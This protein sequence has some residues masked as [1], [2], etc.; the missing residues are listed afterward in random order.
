MG[1]VA[2][3]PV[4]P[5]LAFV[6]LV[7]MSRAMRNKARWVSVAAILGSLGLSIAAF[8]HVWPGGHAGEP[9]YHA[10]MTLATLGGVPLQVGL[11]LDAVSAAM[12][13]VI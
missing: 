5:A 13:I 6:V 11:M 9:V 3:I 7:P 1:Y 2:A 10:T 8:A 12:L 4:L